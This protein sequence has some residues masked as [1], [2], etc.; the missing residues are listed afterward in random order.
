MAERIEIVSIVNYNSG[1]SWR[2]SQDEAEYW[3]LRL[4]IEEAK[5]QMHEQLKRALEIAEASYVNK[6]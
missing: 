3:F 5:R 6:P 1:L 2:M 4:G